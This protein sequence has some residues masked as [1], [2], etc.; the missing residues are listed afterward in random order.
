M[1]FDE[2]RSRIGLAVPICKP[3]TTTS[4]LGKTTDE[5]TCVLNVAQR[6]DT[7]ASVPCSEVR[8]ALAAI[9]VM[10]VRAAFQ[11]AYDALPTPAMSGLPNDVQDLL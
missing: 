5:A 7:T 1:V 3:P 8:L 6:F 10:F 2:S 4:G 9:Q 11:E